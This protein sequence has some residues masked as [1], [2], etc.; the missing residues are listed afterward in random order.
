MNACVQKDGDEQKSSIAE[1]GRFACKAAHS[2]GGI[3]NP[4]CGRANGDAKKTYIIST[5]RIHQYELTSNS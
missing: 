4:D 5:S 3:C 2:S 1:Q